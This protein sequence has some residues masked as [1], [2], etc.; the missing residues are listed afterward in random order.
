MAIDDPLDA[1]QKQLELEESSSS[2][3]SRKMIEI[4]AASPKG[5]FLDAIIGALAEIG[6]A[7]DRH[8]T[9]VLIDTL[10]SEVQRLNS[11]VEEL[12][13]NLTPMEFK[14]RTESASRLLLDAYR[15]AM[16]TRAMERVKR[17]ATILAN[18]IA[19]PRPLDE[20]EIEEMMRVATEL[21]DRDV[22]Y[23][24]E[25][26]LIEGNIVRLNGRIDRYQAH[27]QWERGPWGSKIES[28]IDSIFSKLESYG[29]VSR[30]PPPNNLNIGADFQNRYVLLSKGLRFTELI[31]REAT[32]KN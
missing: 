10:V 9:K 23:L 14:V 12:Q 29:L 30:I 28:Q 2:S 20:D 25:L 5:W 1:L 13:S 27:M 16:M 31:Q 19:D 32:A 6:R 3:I 11:K 17:I 18:G 26:V 24:R 7:D 15:K 4:L 21:S 22:N 8:K